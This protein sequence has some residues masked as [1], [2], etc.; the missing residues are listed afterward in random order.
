MQAAETAVREVLGKMKMDSAL[1]EERDQIAP[2][3]R[4]LMRRSAGRAS[5]RA[6][7][8]VA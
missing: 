1:A 8:P 3:I 2:R 7:S 4:A 5:C 6:P